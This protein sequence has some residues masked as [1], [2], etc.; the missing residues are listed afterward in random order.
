M[1]KIYPLLFIIIISTSSCNLAYRTLL[2]I[3]T[4]PSWKTDKDIEKDFR[5]KNI[6]EANRFVLDTASYDKTVKADLRKT[7]TE[8]K[9]DTANYDTVY[10]KK[11]LKIANDDLQAVQIRYFT[12]TGEPIF[13]LVNCYIDPPI[14]MTWN[15]ENSF[16]VFPPKNDI[17]LLQYNQ[18]ISYFFPHI[19]TLK[20][21]SVSFSNLPAADYYAIVYWNDFMKRPSKKLIKKLKRYNKKHDNQTTHFL[22]VNNHNA[23]IWSHTNDV[24]KEDLK[25]Q[26]KE[27]NQKLK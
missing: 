21:E 14:P 24:Q 22:F 23:S 9:K 4:S 27:E 1:R 6:A 20:G 8:L 13:K 16:D 11:L 19:K 18:P 5:K 3:D 15:V 25:K 10:V 12:K 17:P 2:G 7:V 26:L